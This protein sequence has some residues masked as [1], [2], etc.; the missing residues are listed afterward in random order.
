MGKYRLTFRKSVAQDMR[1]MPNRAVKQILA[2]IE[3][4]SEDPRPA[5]SQ[6]LSGQERYRFRKGDYR[7][8]Y[9]IDDDSSVLIVK[10]GHRWDVYP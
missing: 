6:R 2:A 1:Y 5:G 4:L 8:I 7:I 9:A 3:S 10:V